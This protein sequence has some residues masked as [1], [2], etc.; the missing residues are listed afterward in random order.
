MV[1]GPTADRALFW[2]GHK[3]PAPPSRSADPPI[4]A[5][6]P[7]HSPTHRLHN[8]SQHKAESPKPQ[9]GQ[10]ITM[11]TQL[12]EMTSSSTTF[13]PLT[14]TCQQWTCGVPVLSTSPNCMMPPHTT[15]MHCVLYGTVCAPCSLHIVGGGSSC[16]GA[17]SPS[18]NHSQ[19]LNEISQLCLLLWGWQLL[20]KYNCS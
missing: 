18:T 14:E 17:V 13:I 3:S 1:Y 10:F 2:G 6:T 19:H 8:S 4:L 15:T 16:V 20:L 9:G 5:A 11:S 7:S 12:Y